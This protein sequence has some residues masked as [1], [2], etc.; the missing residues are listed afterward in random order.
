MH[1]LKFGIPINRGFSRWGR[2]LLRVS[3]VRDGLVWREGIGRRERCNPPG[4]SHFLTRDLFGQLC[5][6]MPQVNTAST[7]VL[8]VPFAAYMTPPI[9]VS[10]MY[11]GSYPFL[12]FVAALSSLGAGVSR[13]LWHDAWRSELNASQHVNSHVK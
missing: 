3:R 9:V 5:F 10:D 1:I 11:S 6:A 12:S 8:A 2:R 7:A 4:S 13:V